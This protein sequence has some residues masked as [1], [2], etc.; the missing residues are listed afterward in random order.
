MAIY[1]AFP[2]KTWD[3]SFDAVL[4][5]KQL[6]VELPPTI[7][8]RTN[9]L[10]GFHSHWDFLG[11]EECK[12]EK[13][14]NQHM[15][16]S[17]RSQSEHDFASAFPGYPIRTESLERPG[18]QRKTGKRETQDHGRRLESPGPEVQSFTVKQPAATD[19]HFR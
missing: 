9:S 5:T 16:D 3:T 13:R 4:E 7:S 19:E 6:P 17:E 18:Q 10:L 1:Q 2:F 11:N 12:L 8:S 15:N 14:Q